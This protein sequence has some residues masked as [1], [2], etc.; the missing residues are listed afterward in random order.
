MTPDF[1]LSSMIYFSAEVD[2]S[3]FFLL[4][5]RT[6]ILISLVQKGTI[7]IRGLGALGGVATLSYSGSGHLEGD[8]NK[9]MSY[10]EEYAPHN[11]LKEEISYQQVLVLGEHCP[12]PMLWRKLLPGGHYILGFDGKI[13]T[14][15]F[16][17]G[18]SKRAYSEGTPTEIGWKYQSF[19]FVKLVKLS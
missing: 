16:K 3:P 8:K 18:P 4:E 11:L 1:S 19:E 2:L 7:F 14:S 10:M 12:D 5:M 15:D 17:A 9:I 13:S 6:A